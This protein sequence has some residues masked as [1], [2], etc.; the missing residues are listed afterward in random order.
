MKLSL[1]FIGTGGFGAPV[2]GSLISSNKFRLP[3]VITGEDTKAG[4]SFKLTSSAIKN[5][6]LANNLIVHE[7]RS[8]SAL[9]QKIMQEKPD[10]LLVVDFGEIIPED[11]LSIAKIG[12]VNI[13]PSLLPKYRGASPLQETILHGDSVTGVSWILM[14]NKMD[15]GPIVAQ[16][17][18]A[19][20][21]TD[22]FYS[23]S[24]KLSALAAKETAGVLSNFAHSPAAQ[25]QDESMATYCRKITKE[26][27]FI[28][29]HKETAEQILRKIRAYEA[30]P[31]CFIFWNGK[32][33]KIIQAATGE[34]KISSG[35]VAA[36]DGK[37]LALGTRKDALLPSVVQ[38]ESKC[39]MRIEEF[40]RGQKNIPQ[41]I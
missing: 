17:R 18:I 8:I 15:A 22:A 36:E 21:A 2:I 20:S 3:F 16:K 37:V 6:A 39:E 30:W 34:Q 11:V 40:L 35:M 19:V 5:C 27:G 29:L 38:P 10:F 28:D 7:S 14:S 1:I 13:H 9:R 41:R 31:G 4:R 32:R 24:K 33:L 12:A 26:D 23:L 25:K